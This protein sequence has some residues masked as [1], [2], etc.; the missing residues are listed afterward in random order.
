LA[1][2]LNDVLNGYSLPTL[3]TLAGLNNLAVKDGKAKSV[4]VYLLAEF[5][6]NRGHIQKVYRE[7]QPVE[8]EVV[9]TLMHQKGYA[10]AIAIERRLSSNKLIES[11]AKKRPYTAYNQP[12][13]NKTVPQRFED[14]MARLLVKGLVF[15]VRQ[16]NSYNQPALMDFNQVQEYFIPDA[17]RSNLPETSSLPSWVPKKIPTPVL[18]KESSARS[19]QRDLYFYWSFLRSNP[20]QLT[21]R[22]LIP[23]RNLTSLNE[24]LLFREVIGPGQGE[25][26]FPRL[27][28]LRSML[29]DLKLIKIDDSV[30]RIS[31]DSSFFI[32]TPLERM[33]T[34]FE[35]YKTSQ[36]VD[37]LAWCPNISI[38]VNAVQAYPTPPLIVDARKIA[39]TAVKPAT[40]W[41]SIDHLLEHMQDVDYEFLFKRVYRGDEFNP[42]PSY[43]YPS[44]PYTPYTN[45]LGWN[46]NNLSNNSDGW[47]QVEGR[48]IRY[49]LGRSLYWMGLVNLGFS[50]LEDDLPDFFCLSSMGAWLLSDKQPPEI[51]SA[52]GRVILQPN[53]RITAFDPVSD[54]I[55]LN[56]ES[57]CER[58]STDRAIEFHLT[59]ASVYAGQQQNWDAKRILVYLSEITGLPVPDNIARTLREWQS[60]H[61]RVTIYPRVS[62]LHVAEPEDL[63]KLSEDPTLKV[64]LKERPVPDLVILVGRATISKLVNALVKQAWLPIL[65]QAGKKITPGVVEIYPDGQLRFT[66]PTPDFYLHGH[67]R[68][69]ADSDGQGG[70]RLSMASIQRAVRNGIQAP[71]ILS[72]IQKVIIGEIPT[73]LAQR[74]LAWSGHY[75]EASLEEV[76]LFQVQNEGIL[77][78]LF[79]DP[80]LGRLLHPLEQQSVNYTARVHPK[81]LPRLRQLLE[82]RGIKSK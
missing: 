72:E 80:E 2:T 33:K 59:R 38:G 1:E 48:F 74:I 51:V 58:V 34:C 21:A 61:E 6:G 26:D 57:F 60:L 27:V 24:T 79:D 10:S 70:Y 78:E 30:L 11:L 23:K 15:G 49:I 25:N 13:F 50:K 73:V 20:V 32:K 22:G 56:L 3:T 35:V 44:H 37:E 45:P 12:D 14:V 18:I 71:E 53:F 52:G 28:F 36:S 4:Y 54:E 67:L 68:R 63:E 31:S 42:Y 77:K 82:E 41:A 46:F 62:L 9:D 5:F 40:G 81:D 64:F 55:L 65:L 17:I 69:F 39:L 16:L 66:V 19:F 7:L 8:R 43:G 29:S 76:I 47:D 75:G